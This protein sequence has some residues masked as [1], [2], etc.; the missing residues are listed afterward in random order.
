M[1]HVLTSNAIGSGYVRHRNEQ[2]GNVNIWYQSILGFID[3]YTYSQEQ[4]IL[5]Y[6]SF[7]ILF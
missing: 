7:S 4:L 6:F 1:T 5:P 3:L 2:F